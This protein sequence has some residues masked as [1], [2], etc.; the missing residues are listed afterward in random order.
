MGRPG[1][2]RPLDGARALAI[3]REDVAY[4]EALLGAAPSAAAARAARAAQR[5]IHA[6]NVARVG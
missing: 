5:A 4:L 2:R 6:E 1:P 3:L